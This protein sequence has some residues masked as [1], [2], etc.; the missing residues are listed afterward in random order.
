[1]Q[2][3]SLEANLDVTR[4]PSGAWYQS[5]ALGAVIGATHR[6]LGSALG[7]FAF[8]AFWNGIVSVFVALERHFTPL[9]GT[10]A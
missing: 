1:V 4:P 5:S 8:S 7:L 6:S 10:S 3:V 2:G 9:K